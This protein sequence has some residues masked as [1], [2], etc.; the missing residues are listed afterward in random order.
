MKFKISTGEAWDE[1]FQGSYCALH[2]DSAGRD[3]KHLPVV[4]DLGVGGQ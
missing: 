3:I 4:E 1:A 2:C